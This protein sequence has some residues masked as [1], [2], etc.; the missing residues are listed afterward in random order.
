MILHGTCRLYFSQL[1]VDGYGLATRLYPPDKRPAI[2][3]VEKERKLLPVNQG[4]TVTLPT[5]SCP[6]SF[7]VMLSGLLNG[8]C[9]KLFEPAP[10]ILPLTKTRMPLPIGKV[11][12]AS[13]ILAVV[14]F[15]CV[16]ILY[17]GELLIFAA[18]FQL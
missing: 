16:P 17:S 18:L 5:F 3:V 14:V 2:V 11:I 6:V 4:L 10:A 13:A 15:C 9:V 1:I 12:V 8:G 7:N